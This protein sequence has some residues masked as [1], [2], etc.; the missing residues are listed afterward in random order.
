MATVLDARSQPE[1]AI[2]AAVAALQLGHCVVLPTDTIYGIGAD[3]TNPAAVQGLLEAKE[4]DRDMP[5]PV[6]I[7]EVGMLRALTDEVGPELLALADAFWPGAL[8]VVLTAH[9]HLRMDLGDR[10]ETIAVRIP[11]HDFTREL[12]RATGPLAVSSANISGHEPATT[13]D[14]A[15]A[16]LGERVAVYLDDGP[17]SIGAASTIVDL[18][19]TPQILREGH[20]SRAELAAVLPALAEPAAGQPDSAAEPASEPN[21][22]D[23]AVAELPDLDA[24]GLP[25]GS[26]AGAETVPV[27]PDPEA[28]EV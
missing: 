4:R 23:V 7:A 16:Q 22:D 26:A 6:L 25:P 2:D 14:Q 28:G 12:L 15:V 1:A 27:A 19:G 11:D 17:S 24:E 9:S 18:T 20:L 3:A 13:I 21:P 8:T 10:G 5:P